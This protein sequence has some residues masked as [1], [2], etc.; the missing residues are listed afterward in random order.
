LDYRDR[1]SSTTTNFTDL[2]GRSFN[3]A[4]I[5]DPATTRSVAAASADP[6][7]GLVASASGFVRDPFYTGGSSAGITDF[8]TAAQMNLMNQLAS[9]RIDSNAL[10]LLQLYPAANGPGFTNN[11]FV[12]RSQPDDNNHFDVRGDVIFSQSDQAFGRVSYSRR[13]ANFPGDFTGDADNTGFGQ[14]DFTDRSLNLA[15]SETHTFSSTL[16]NEARFGY[17]H[18]RTSS[19]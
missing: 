15:V 6:S 11:Y 1:F 18:L 19:Q 7:T 12:N 5:F 14:G 2:L 8:T 17:S 9:T 10:N 13:H 16:I 4:T 3:G